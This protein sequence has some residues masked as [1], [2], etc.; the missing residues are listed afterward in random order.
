MCLAGDREAMTR[1]YADGIFFQ[2]LIWKSC[3]WQK[4][5]RIGFIVN[6]EVTEP[7]ITNA[8]TRIKLV[9]LLNNATTL[10]LKSMSRSDNQSISTL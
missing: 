9:G 2:G 3:E 10:N 1:L 5:S 4:I 7:M 8:V 6:L